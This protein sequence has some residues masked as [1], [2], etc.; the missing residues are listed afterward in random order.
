M[1]DPEPAILEDLRLGLV[2]LDR[3]GLVISYGFARDSSGGW[4]GGLAK[5][6]L[7]CSEA[8]PLLGLFSFTLPATPP[9]LRRALKPRAD[10][11]HG[12]L[13]LLRDRN[14]RCFRLLDPDM[15]PAGVLLPAAPINS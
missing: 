12:R 7:M 6:F 15:H 5:T 3:R 14:F 2:A 13:N 4:R 8:S 11:W 9:G 10:V 1:D